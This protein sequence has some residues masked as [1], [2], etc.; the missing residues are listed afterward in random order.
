MPDEPL[1]VVMLCGNDQTS[2]LMFH[3][4]KTHASIQCVIV[5]SRA[6]N[7]ALA[8][9]RVKRLGYLKVAGQ[10]LFIACNRVLARSSRARIRQII[11]ESGMDDGDFQECQVIHVRTINSPEVVELLARMHPEAV[12]VNGTRILSPEILGAVPVPFINTHVGMTP[13]YRGVHGG[14]WALA[15]GDPDHCGVTVHLVDPGIDT[16]GVLYQAVIR[17]DRRDN[18]NTYPV[19]QLAAAIPLMRAALEDVK[20]HRLQVRTGILPSRLWSH[21]TLFQYLKTWLTRGIH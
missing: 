20:H 7:L 15:N 5:E 11:R 12:V 4:L 14:Y 19:R 13:K 2:R 18:F 3:G 16:G 1:R 6:S 8:R 10:L 17:T 9:R 21:P